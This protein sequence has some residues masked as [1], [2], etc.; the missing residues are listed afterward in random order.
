MADGRWRPGLAVAELLPALEQT[1][2]LGVAGAVL[3]TCAA[4]PIAWLSIRSPG[5]LQRCWK[6]ATTSPV[7]CPALSWRW[8]WS[9]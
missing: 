5:R 9:R 7:H 4:I 3:T 1:L 6:A 8:R 2:L